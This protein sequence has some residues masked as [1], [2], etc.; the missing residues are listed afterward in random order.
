MDAVQAIC[1]TLSTT[2][3][4][5]QIESLSKKINVTRQVSPHSESPKNETAMSNDSPGSDTS[6]HALSRDPTSP[7]QHPPKDSSPPVL[8]GALQVPRIVIPR[9]R[10]STR[11]S[12]LNKPSVSEHRRSRSHDGSTHIAPVHTSTTTTDLKLAEPQTVLHVPGSDT[13]LSPPTDA[14]DMTVFRD[15]HGPE[16]SSPGPPETVQSHKQLHGDW[17]VPHR[18]PPQEPKPRTEQS[19]SAV[20]VN[21]SD[22][23]E[24]HMANDGLKQYM[25]SMGATYPDP[26]PSTFAGLLPRAEE[27]AQKF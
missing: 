14:V 11:L 26:R 25:Q 6:G 3:L 13:A 17:F 24:K 18:K 15:P 1:G 21:E 8:S 12:P 20:S 19:I 16:E 27:V 10:S 9:A 4:K 22:D 7:M 23:A 2:E 5:R